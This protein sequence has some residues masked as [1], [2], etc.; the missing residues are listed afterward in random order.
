MNLTDEQTGLLDSFSEPSFENGVFPDSWDR[1]FQREILSMLLS[2][3]Y[4]LIQSIDMINPSYFADDVHK[5]ICGI[6]FKYFKEYSEIP[7]K[8]YVQHEIKPSIEAPSRR[9][10]HLSEIN[11]LCDYYQPG[12]A[13]RSYLVDKIYNFAQTQQFKLAVGESIDLLKQYGTEEDAGNKV[14]DKVRTALLFEKN[15]DFGLDYF[16]T[17]K[18]RYDRVTSDEERKDRFIT[19][20]DTVDQN[21]TGGGLGCGV[22]VGVI[23]S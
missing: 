8:S 3:R 6:L 20:M 5:K 19:G 4:F 12:L 7:R 23:A 14:K 10:A 9:A 2:D 18:D 17:Y 16:G 1:D 11:V 13:N 22:F 15:F 21:I